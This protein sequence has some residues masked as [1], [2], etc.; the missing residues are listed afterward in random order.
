MSFPNALEGVKKIYRA[1]IIALISGILAVV[2][3]FFA[4]FGLAAE[5]A[6]LGEGALAGLLS[7]GLL[8]IVVAVLAI[9]A[10]IMNIVGLVKAKTDDDNFKNA[11]YVVIVGIVSSIIVSAS[12]SKGGLLAD[13]GETV[14]D[15]CSFLTT[16]FV[17]SA[18]VNLAEKLNDSAIRQKAVDVRKIVMIIWWCTIALDIISTIVGKFDGNTVLSYIVSVI[19]VFTAILSVISYILYLKLLSK[20]RTM[21]EA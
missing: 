13:L 17:C 15:I 4:L 9:I 20:A 19:G 7:G 2:A 6:G 10:F 12:S 18:I 21:L 11:L 8:M 5:A 16:W 3:A 14:S 1:E